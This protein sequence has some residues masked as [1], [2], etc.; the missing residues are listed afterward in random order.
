MQLQI[1]NQQNM[2][3]QMANTNVLKILAEATQQE[4]FDHIFPSIPIFF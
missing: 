3:A 1:E 4:N 2:A